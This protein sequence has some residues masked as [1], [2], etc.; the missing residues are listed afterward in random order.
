MNNTDLNRLHKLSI[1]ADNADARLRRTT[2]TIKSRKQGLRCCRKRLA[3]AIEMIYLLQKEAN[4]D[5]ELDNILIHYNA[6]RVIR[7]LR[8]LKDSLVPAVDDLLDT[9]NA[10]T[11]EVPHGNNKEPL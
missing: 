3:L 4:S 5:Q 11:K 10:L 1:L 6:R 2:D 7:E 9:H 8:F